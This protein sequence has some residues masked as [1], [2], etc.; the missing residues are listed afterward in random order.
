MTV[1]VMITNGGAHP[2]EK[3]AET[4]AGCIVQIADHVAGERRGAAIKLQAAIYD[5]LVLHHAIVQREEKDQLSAMGAAGLLA[6]LDHGR[7]LDEVVGQ[8]INCGV[9]TPW[10][11]DFRTPE[12]DAGLRELLDRHFRTQK[13]VERSWHADQHPDTTEARVFRANHHPGAELTPGAGEA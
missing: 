8:I 1:G 9:D 12:F 5:V 3:W 2:P 4:T 13:H 7:D 6:P 11:K 10:E